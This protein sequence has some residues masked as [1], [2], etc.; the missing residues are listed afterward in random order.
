M[1]PTTAHSL[2]PTCA[3]H[4]A[5]EQTT[6]ASDEPPK[7]RAQFFY[8][9][10]LPIDDP[11]SPIP[12]LRPESKSAQASHPP[13]PFSAVDNAAL[14]EAWQGF[15]KGETPD[16]NAVLLDTRPTSRGRML[17]G[18]TRFPKFRGE[19]RS[20]ASDESSRIEA[21][22]SPSV[23]KISQGTEKKPAC[24][25]LRANGR[26]GELSTIASDEELD[27]ATRYNTLLQPPES[28]SINPQSA[29][30]TQSTVKPTATQSFFED[31]D[32]SATPVLCDEGP[33][34]GKEISTQLE[35]HDIEA[36]DGKQRRK[37]KF[38][39]FRS[40]SKVSE[41]DRKDAPESE[42]QI[43]QIDGQAHSSPAIAMTTDTYISG[44]PF[45]RAPNDVEVPYISGRGPQS[46]RLS[47]GSVESSKTRLQSPHGQRLFVPIGI[48][49]LHL[50]EFPSLLM[51][52][53]YWSPVNDISNVIRA[54]W[55][56]QNSMT[57]VEP[58]ISNQ[59]ERGYEDM[60]PWT[61]VYVDELNSCIE[62]GAAAEM[63]VTHRLWPEERRSSRPGTGDEMKL[64]NPEA[65][66]A[67]SAEMPRLKHQ[68]NV[69]LGPQG[70][71]P[72]ISKLF[73]NH[74]VIYAN[75]REAQILRPSLIP[76]VS[77]GRRPLA[78]V[79]KGRQIGIAVVR[80]FDRE[81]WN[82]IHPP[83]RLSTRAA[84]A[85]IGGYWSQ[86]GDAT[87][88]GRRMSCFTCRAEEQRPKVTDLVLVIHGI[89][90]KLSERVDS[91]HFTHAINSFRRQV[92]VE[93]SSEAVRGNL[94]DDAGGIMV[95]P[96]NWRLTV[97]FDQ[98]VPK[99]ET[100]END[101]GLEDITPDTLPYLRS[102]I[103]DVMLDV[104]YYLSHHRP[105]MVAAVIREANRVYRLW[106]R[107]NPAFHDYGRV[108]L[109]A[110]SLGSA[111]A[112]DILS[113]QPTTVPKHIDLQSNRINDQMF[114]F[115][116]KSLFCCGS[117]SGFFLLLNKANLLPR[118]GRS[119]P[120]A[121]DADNGPS[122][123]GEA[124]TYGCLAVDNLY[125][126]VAR[127]DPVASLQNAAV[128]RHYAASLVPTY[129]PTVTHSFFEKV[130]NTLGWGATSNTSTEYGVATRSISQRPGLPRL[131]TTV[132][133]ET[134]NFTREEIA[135]KRM[136]LLNDN[137][138]IDFFLSSGGGP[139]DIEY[140]NML[141]AHSSYWVQQDFVRFVVVELGREPG[142][143]GTLTQLRATKKR[144]FKAGKTD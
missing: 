125:N 63:K 1:G 105:K 73:K 7:L 96:I 42:P 60:R 90:Q 115:D 85:K 135:E 52:P 100:T 130:S 137:G 79:R 4:E 89:G 121:S 70:P 141:G 8:V 118:K 15:Q 98:D 56:Y 91:F 97:S 88:S 106:C 123:T 65:D 16:K 139:L 131:P 76:S 86:S 66:V 104:P 35:G 99:E 108:H 44:R 36:E 64:D 23:E 128:D 109:I 17:S 19:D 68:E 27:P 47:A 33:E 37:R 133:L 48:S 92:N 127:N 78:A 55:F 74:S 50:V 122:V 72:Q 30:A 75:A 140:I 113:D 3:Y 142:R 49:R 132:E 87:T 11:L 43:S 107:N 9:S 34:H 67:H 95:L 58:D 20:S 59:L 46:R 111:M 14:E 53:I 2:G 119:K 112:M 82:K 38:S 31:Q 124:G 5:N 102:L 41:N 101:Y 62:N 45:A 136:Y 13:Q 144:G 134:H 32:G 28:G 80:G 110:H 12:P 51:K 10:N 22:A 114:E 26:F 39:P 83:P 103:S 54:T 6:K 25:H 40:R 69:A 84:H 57:P 77:K 117:P 61:E 71:G 129:I 21:S 81:A 143:E 138:Q 94:R 24:G 29:L 120:G 18:I 93:L 116:T 126:I